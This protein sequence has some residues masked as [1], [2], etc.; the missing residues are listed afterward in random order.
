MNIYGLKINNTIPRDQIND[1]CNYISTERKNRIEKLHF[2]RDKIYTLFGELLIRYLLGE[3]HNVKKDQIN[4]IK[5][6]YG[7][8]F[9]TNGIFNFNISHSGSYV[10][11]AI[12]SDIVGIDIE[13]VNPSIDLQLAESVFTRSELKRIEN[14]YDPV[15]TFFEL[16]TLKESYIKAVGK[17]LSIPLN[18]FSVDL[19]RLVTND[20]KLATDYYFMQYNNIENHKLA[21]CSNVPDFPGEIKQVSQ[22]HL[23]QYYFNQI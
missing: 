20:S 11:C 7:K 12:S 8:P 13:R 22:S 17:G 15:D 10:V 4:F 19:G 23:I 14:N 16:W 21:V 5:S 3:Y 18:S 2:D 9:L 6:K 1:L